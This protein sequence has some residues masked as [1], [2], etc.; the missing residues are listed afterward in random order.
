[1]KRNIRRLA[2]ALFMST[3]GFM[4]TV[5]WYHQGKTADRGRQIAVAQIGETSNEVQRKP[6]KRVIWENVSKNE[7]LYAGEAIRT[8]ANA[9]AQILVTKSGTKIRLE[10]DSLI[11][12]EENDQGLALDFLQGNMQVAGAGDLTVKTGSG[13]IKL[14][15]ADMSLSK[16]QSGQVNLEMFKGEAELQQGAQKVAIDKNKAATFT[17]KG[18]S[19]AKER[20]QV[21]SPLPGAAILLNLSRGEKVEVQWQA[22]PPG[23]TVSLET[24]KS[25]KQLGRVGAVA[26]ETGRLEFAARPGRQFLRLSAE[27][28]DANLPKLAAVTIPF[29]VD[30]KTPPALVEPAAKAAQ[31]KRDE[32]DPVAF[33]WLNRHSFQ[34]QVLEIS[35]DPMFK[36]VAIKQDLSGEETSFIA[37][38]P[39]GTYHWRVTG[40]LNL[41]G[42]MEALSSPPRSFNVISNW[43]A[44]PPTLLFP[45]PG[46]R[47]SYIEVQRNLG[48]NLKWQQPQGVKRFKVRVSKK[49]NAGDKPVLEKTVEAPGVKL[50]DPTPGHYVWQVASIDP[51]DESEKMSEPSEF[52]IDELPPLEW[53]ETNPNNEYEFST[54]TPSLRAQWKGLT[55][56]PAS[57][58]YRVVAEGQNI[59]DGKWQTTKQTVFD[60]SLPAEGRYLASVEALNGKGEAIAASETRLFSIKAKPLLPAPQWTENAPDTLKADGKG[61]LSL[62]WEEVEGASNYLLILENEDGKLVEQKQVER[63]TASLKR[64]KPGDYSVKLKAVDGFKRPGLSGEPKKLTVPNLSNIRAPKIKSMKVK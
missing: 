20:L 55:A 24:G 34:S 58:R 18:L 25:R 46:Q 57:Y 30:P 49:Q 41:N 56:A 50:I 29:I 35:S 51:K 39:D 9:E 17:E 37:D 11:V 42:K 27:S 31:L 22:L 23:Y 52:V 16:D 5:F 7:E 44:K 63:N 1:M 36:Q 45:N 43:E 13:E 8:S 12:L 33:K 15:S 48:V 53:A 19:V 61:N 47:L 64:L 54:P 14:K 4:A 38:L 62:G 28:S 10:P 2:L 59:Q 32:Q 60:V 6:V 21:I 26:G 40:F 3:T